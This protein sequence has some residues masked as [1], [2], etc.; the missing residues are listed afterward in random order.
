M[1]TIAAHTGIVVQA[2]MGSTR[3][4]GKVSMPILGK[5]P[6]EW[7]DHRLRALNLPLVLATSTGSQ[8]DRLEELGNKLGWPV[9]RGS[10][11][12]VLS[13]FAGAASALGL[14]HVV[15]ITADCP[16]VCADIIQQGLQLY[17]T[18]EQGRTYVSNS[19]ERT[20]PRGMDMEI[21][22]TELLLEAQAKAQHAAEREHVTP[23]MYTGNTPA[24]YQAQ[25]RHNHNFSQIRLTLDTAE[26]LLVITRS[27]Q[28][29]L[30]H[31]CLSY[32]DM[33]PRFK[34]HEALFALNQHVEQK[35]TGL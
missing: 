27:M 34:G 29:L 17:A 6:L 18:L 33:W 25:V 3:L 1:K 32:E 10:E 28:E 15:R 22:S 24:T 9:F 11:T 4:P 21:F 13:R 5:S 31:E 12:D 2:R 14:K 30:L 20:Y 23:Y 8:D 19:L 7:I 26:D 35:K 16:L